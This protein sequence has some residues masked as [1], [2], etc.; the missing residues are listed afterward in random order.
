MP[1]RWKALLLAAGVLGL[2]LAGIP[3]AYAGVPDVNAS[4]YVPQAGNTTTPLEGAST[5]K[6]FSFFRGCPNNDGASYANNSRVKVVVRDANGNG[7]PGVSASDIC[8]LFN[9]GTPIQGHQ[10][11]GG[12]TERAVR[13][14]LLVP[15]EVM[16]RQIISLLGMGGPSF[17]MA[18]HYNHIHLGF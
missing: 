2:V 7:I 4:F 13:D 16:P 12:I 11:P 14:L 15:S 5:P 18:D 9:G 17:P 3:A 10:E 1:E 8:L 6:S